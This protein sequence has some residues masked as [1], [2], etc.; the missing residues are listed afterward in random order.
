MAKPYDVLDISC[1]IINKHNELYKDIGITN[2]R[3]QKILY[4]VQRYFCKVLKKPCFKE[5]MEAWKFGVICKQSY[6]EFLIYSGNKIPNIDKYNKIDK[7][8]LT[9]KTVKYDE[10]KINKKD[11]K[12]IIKVI[13]ACSDMTDSEL[14][15][16]SCNQ[17]PWINAYKEGEKNRINIEDL[18]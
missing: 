2:L 18:Y 6:N 8:T 11:K 13:K 3:L 16:I 12:N 17:T 9:F 7:N 1:F 10:D 5:D 15:D 14:I 4:F